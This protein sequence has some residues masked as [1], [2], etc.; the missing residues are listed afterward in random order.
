MKNIDVIERYF[1]LNPES[2]TGFYYKNTTIP[3]GYKHKAKDG[4]MW[5][6]KRKAPTKR[7]YKQFMFS[8]DRVIYEMTHGVEVKRNQMISHIDGNKDNH[9]PENLKLIR[10]NRHVKQREKNTAFIAF[11]N[12]ILPKTNPDYFKDPQDW[13][14][15]E[16]LAA[17][18]RERELRAQGISKITNR[19]GNVPTWK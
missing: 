9:K 2:P 3:A 12:V 6:L 5:V 14:D 10:D 7:G 13:T 15:P 17:L 1:T 16:A 19:L 4:Y 8:L 18:E 11:R